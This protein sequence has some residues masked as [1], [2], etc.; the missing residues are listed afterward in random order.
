MFSKTAVV[1]VR[2]R[3]TKGKSAVLL[4]EC[5]NPLQIKFIKA[6]LHENNDF[7][8]SLIGFLLQQVCLTVK[9]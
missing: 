1:N 2:T 6:V 7:V 5:I 8:F 9:K 4:T 3:G